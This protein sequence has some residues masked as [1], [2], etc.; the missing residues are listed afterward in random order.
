MTKCWIKKNCHDADINFRINNQYLQN[1]VT[2][3]F[4]NIL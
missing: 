4:E 3:S 2:D 1:N